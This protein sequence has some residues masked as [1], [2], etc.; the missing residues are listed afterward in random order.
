[1]D[2]IK[3]N[4]KANIGMLGVPI[5]AIVGPLAGSIIGFWP[6]VILGSIACYLLIWL[7]KNKED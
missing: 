7:P 2:F 5:Y 4:L 1:M 3:K 6:T